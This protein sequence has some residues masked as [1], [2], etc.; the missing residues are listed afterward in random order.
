MK[1]ES[2]LGPC[3]RWLHAT[4]ALT[5]WQQDADFMLPDWDDEDDFFS[6]AH[7]FLVPLA[8]VKNINAFSISHTQLSIRWIKLYR[9]EA[10]PGSA[11]PLPPFFALLLHQ[12]IMQF[13]KRQKGL[14]FPSNLAFKG[15]SAII[16]RQCPDVVETRSC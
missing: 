2:D 14:N 6:S 10:N 9:K 4:Q 5:L 8:K 15:Y 11:V 7:R 3:Q 13:Y 12:A 1:Y 16:A